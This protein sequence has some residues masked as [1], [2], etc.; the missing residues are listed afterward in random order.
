M[1]RRHPMLTSPSP[2]PAPA[3]A[4]QRTD[5]AM[6][7][8]IKAAT[9]EDVRWELL[10]KL[11]RFRRPPEVPPPIRVRVGSS[12]IT[13]DDKTTADAFRAK[14]DAIAGTAGRGVEEQLRPWQ[15]HS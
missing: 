6:V 4:A 11:Y 1:A 9:S 14:Y 12:G 13:P 5:R 10:S 3:S 15:L 8:S 7:E 2:S